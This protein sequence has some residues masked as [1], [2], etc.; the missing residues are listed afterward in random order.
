VTPQSSFTVLAPVVEGAAEDLRALLASM[1][2]RPSP[3]R[4]ACAK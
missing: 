4:P 1:N 3:I 2:I